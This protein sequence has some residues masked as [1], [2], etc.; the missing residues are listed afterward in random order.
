MINGFTLKVVAITGMTCNHVANVFAAQLPQP[1]LLALF[2]L[3]GVTF[4][5]M[6]FLL[7]EGFTH[8][9]NLQKYAARLAVFACV[10][11]VPYSLL[12]GAVPNVLFTLLVGL[13]LLWLYDHAHKGIF[14]LATLLVVVLTNSFDWG[15]IGPLM[16]VLFYLLRESGKVPSIIGPMGVAYL[17]IGLPALAEVPGLAITGDMS[18]LPSNTIADAGHASLVWG[19]V[20]YAGIGFT[21]ACIL[22]G[23]YNGKRGPSMKWFFY[24][25]Y[26]AHLL[27]IWLI[28]LV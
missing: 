1:L 2:S 17:G 23:L 4:P 20:G 10:A 24:A 18:Y 9:S 11:Q 25:Y 19:N 5:I 26:P 27:L 13:G 15:S 3:G 21:G 6:A 16:V 8:T 7:V 12:W 14:W 22:L 28:T